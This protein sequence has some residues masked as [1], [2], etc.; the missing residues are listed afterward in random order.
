MVEK[1]TEIDGICE[2]AIIDEEAIFIRCSEFQLLSLSKGEDTGLSA[3]TI[4]IGE[5]FNLADADH[6]S[7]TYQL[8]GI[9]G[10]S[11]IFEAELT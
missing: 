5:H 2:L 6:I 7:E 11:A 3:A 9:Q 10:G 4:H 8:V 1:L